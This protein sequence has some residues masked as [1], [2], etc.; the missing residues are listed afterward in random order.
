MLHKH[1]E[2]ITSDEWKKLFN[3]IPLIQ[4]SEYFGEW[5]GLEKDPRGNIQLPYMVRSRVVQDFCNLI[6]ELDLLV[7]FDWPNWTAGRNIVKEGN[8]KNLDTI[9]LIKILTA[10]IRND[11]F[12]E[13]AL[14]EAFE[15]GTIE[16]ILTVLKTNIEN[17]SIK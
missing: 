5:K 1:L 7:G 15:N 8:F 10:I 11:R 9:T 13:G 17:R 14:V 3:F 12:C 4:S 6:Y 16:K 2:T